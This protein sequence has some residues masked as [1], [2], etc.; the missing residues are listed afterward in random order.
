MRG[1]GDVSDPED[2][3][4]L[5]LIRCGDNSLYTGITTDVSRRLGQHQ[6]RDGKG[7]GAKFLRGKQ[8]LTLVFSAPIGDRSEA[9][10]IEYRVKQL[11][12]SDKEALVSRQLDI[13]TLRSQSSGD[14]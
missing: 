5:Y 2:C 6:N 10:K 1:G 3:W 13:D 8:P 11:G 7:K 14:E 9:Q 4:H 12:K